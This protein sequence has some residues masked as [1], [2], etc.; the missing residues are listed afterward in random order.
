MAK[1]RE[2]GKKKKSEEDEEGDTRTQ[3]RG[4]RGR[5]Q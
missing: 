3:E 4:K 1:R 5:F 2:R